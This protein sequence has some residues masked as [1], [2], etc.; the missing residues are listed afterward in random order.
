MKAMIF[1]V[2]KVMISL[3]LMLEMTECM[4]IGAMVRSRFADSNDEAGSVIGP[5]LLFFSG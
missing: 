4:V 5:A 1:F 3:T 2:V